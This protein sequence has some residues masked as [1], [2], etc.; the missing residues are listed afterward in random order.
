MIVTV[1]LLLTALGS[2]CLFLLMQYWENELRIKTEDEPPLDKA[3]IATLEEIAD[4]QQQI[5][6]LEQQILGLETQKID[7]TQQIEQFQ[8][9]LNDGERIVFDL[10]LQKDQ[11]QKIT[12]T[13]RNE[14]HQVKETSEEKLEQNQIFLREHQ[15]TIN[16]QRQV[17]EVKQQHIQQLDDKVRDLTYEIKTLLHLAEKSQIQDQKNFTL[18]PLQPENGI[19]ASV[20]P[21]IHNPQVGKESL[22]S[23]HL[24]HCIDIAQKMTGASHYGNRSGKRAELSAEH[25]VLD[26]RCLIDSLRNENSCAI[27]IYSQKENK[28][29]FANNQIKPLL[30]WNSEKF[31]QN[32]PTIIE[33]SATDWNAALSQLAYKNE[34]QTDLLM[35]SKNGAMVQVNCQLGVIAT[36]IFRS[37]ILALLYTR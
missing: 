28:I 9:E 18:N 29:I 16:E 8:L 12:D 13:L 37:N 35:R 14:L 27:L 15:Q 30:G 4:L 1:G 24:K 34:C 11:L 7:L 25:Y 10:K 17:I 20:Q 3:P 19:E 22:A 33:E 32:F 21:F 36:G 31:I 5:E 23:S 2:L 26:L 6:K